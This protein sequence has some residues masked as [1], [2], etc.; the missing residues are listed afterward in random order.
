MKFRQREILLKL[1]NKKNDGFYYENN[2]FDILIHSVLNTVKFDSILE[3]Y[4]KNSLPELNFSL[5]SNLNKRIYLEN[6]VKLERLYEYLKEIIE[7]NRD[8][9][10]S[11]RLRLAAELLLQNL[12]DSYKSDFFNTFFYSKYL[13]DKKAALKYLVY[14]KKNVDIDLLNLFIENR[15]PIFLNPI[16]KRKNRKILNDNF[17]KIWHQELWFTY[18]KKILESM[19]PISDEIES[20]IKNEEEDLYLQLLGKNINKVDLVNKIENVPDEKRLFYIWQASK[21]LNFE[22][23]EDYIIEILAKV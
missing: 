16:L 2:P 13:N 12:S 22:D 20:F 17:F 7:T 5:I 3:I 21:C 8:Y 9:K 1:Y 18:K 19:F 15:N 4:I 6:K 23:I 14:S 11:Q 10:Y